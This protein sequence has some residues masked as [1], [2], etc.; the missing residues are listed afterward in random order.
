MIKEN[1]PVNNCAWKI[2]K[3]EVRSAEIRVSVIDCLHQCT[4]IKQP[5]AL[6]GPGLNVELLGYIFTQIWGTD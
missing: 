4:C 2:L 5:P 3:A 1:I 6:I